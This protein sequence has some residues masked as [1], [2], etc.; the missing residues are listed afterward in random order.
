MARDAF[1]LATFKDQVQ[2]AELNLNLVNAS[3]WL[4]SDPPEPD[5]ILEGIV[6]AGDKMAVIGS[7]K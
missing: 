1:M 4:S 7:S 6:D 2:N 5:Q 3:E